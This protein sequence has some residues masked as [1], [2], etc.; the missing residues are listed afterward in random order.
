M[1]KHILLILIYGTILEPL[2]GFTFA[3]LMWECLNEN[4]STGGW[5]EVQPTLCSEWERW[6][7]LPME[8]AAMVTLLC[9][10]TSDPSLSQHCKAFSIVFFK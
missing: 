6:P 2:E 5:G 4:R 8:A 3:C 9:W 7:T 1:D 10:G